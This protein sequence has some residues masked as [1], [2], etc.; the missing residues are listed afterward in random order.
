MLVNYKKSG[1]VF[2]N[3]FIVYPLSTDSRITH[4]LHLS[5][6]IANMV[7]GTK[8]M[9]IICN[10]N[11]QAV[12]LAPGQISAVPAQQTFYNGTQS[13]QASNT[14]QQP[15]AHSTPQPLMGLAPVLS[16]TLGG[17]TAQNAMLPPGL[18]VS[19]GNTG[20]AQYSLGDAKRSHDSMNNGMPPTK[21]TK[22]EGSVVKN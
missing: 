18:A 20:M 15:V 11:P 5:S 7:K 8:K 14:V 2:R 3:F 10:Q 12:P 19:V 16:S 9:K 22:F 13:L 4:Y 6:N 17:P 1:E 21:Q